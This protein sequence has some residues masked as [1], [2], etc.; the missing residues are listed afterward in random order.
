M[1]DDVPAEGGLG[2]GCRK[3]N[4]ERS[5][6]K[7]AWRGRSRPGRLKAVLLQLL[8]QRRGGDAQRARRL[9]LVSARGD[10]RLSDGRPFQVAERVAAERQAIEHRLVGGGIDE[11]KVAGLEGTLSRLHEG[12]RTGE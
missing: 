6:P 11:A 8:V 7:A 2:G 12:Q 3:G 9:D 10:Q 4:G 5:E 1:P